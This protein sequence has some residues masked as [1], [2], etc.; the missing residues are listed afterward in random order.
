MDPAIRP[1]MANG[2]ALLRQLR[3]ITG[4]L[5]AKRRVLLLDVN[6]GSISEFADLLKERISDIRVCVAGNKDILDSLNIKDRVEL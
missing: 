4:D 1:S 6:A 3:G 2:L 5:I